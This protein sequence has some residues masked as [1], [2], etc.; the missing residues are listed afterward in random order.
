MESGETD[1]RCSWPWNF[2]KSTKPDWVRDRK[3]SYLV[4]LSLAPDPEL[5]GVPLALDLATDPVGKQMLRVMFSPQEISRPYLAPPGTPAERV[6]ELRTAFAAT[7]NDPGFLAEFGK[8][9]GEPPKPTAGDDMQKMIVDL[10]A[11]PA[12][13]VTRLKGILKY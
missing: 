2:I 7:M 3:L 6:R 10:Y 12:D 5:A 1:G 13:V 8:M 9:F 4:Q 11:T